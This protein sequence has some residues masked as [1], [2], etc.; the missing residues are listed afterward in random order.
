[1]TTETLTIGGMTCGHCLQA[2][3]QALSGLEG[4]TTKD[5]RVGRATVSYDEAAVPAGR[6]AE[7]IR[8]AGYEVLATARED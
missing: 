8:E 6:I 1:M 2:V 4:V 5:L 3:K 7:A